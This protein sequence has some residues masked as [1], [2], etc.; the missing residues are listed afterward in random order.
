MPDYMSQIKIILGSCTL[1]FFLLTA[2]EDDLTYGSGTIAPDQ[3]VW[4]LSNP[5]E[6]NF[7]IPDTSQYFDFQMSVTNT[8]AYEFSNM[9]LFV[10]MKFPNDRWLRDTLEMYVTDRLGR[11]L[12]SSEGGGYENLLLYKYNR[13]MPL[14]GNY[15]FKIEHGMRQ[16]KLKGV[17]KVNLTLKKHLK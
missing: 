1:A 15:Q 9:Y 2:C 4:E 3:D 12:G 13:K 17:R 5:L 7:E 8:D 11:Q 14:P 10:N 16:E 6:F